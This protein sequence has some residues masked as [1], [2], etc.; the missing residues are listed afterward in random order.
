MRVA[1]GRAL[2]AG[3][4][5][6]RRFLGH[7]AFATERHAVALHHICLLPDRVRA[8]ATP[9]RRD[10]LAGWVRDVAQPFAQYRNRIALERGRLFAQRFASVALPDLPALI[11]ATA[12]VELAPVRA[13][14]VDRGGDYRWSS[15]ALLTGGRE[16]SCLPERSMSPSPFYL[17]LGDSPERRAAGFAAWLGS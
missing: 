1:R 10:A 7:L 14:L 11:A 9:H 2:F 13:G 4:R 15:A 5:D 3:T 12:E 8:L 17:A 16:R 6:Y